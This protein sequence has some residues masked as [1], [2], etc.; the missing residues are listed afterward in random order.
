MLNIDLALLEL[1]YTAQYNQAV[2]LE[3]DL[4]RDRASLIFSVD[5]EAVSRE[6]REY[7]KLIILNM[8]DFK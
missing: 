3:K 7:A 2:T 8:E 4:Y 6:Q 1:Q 5:Y